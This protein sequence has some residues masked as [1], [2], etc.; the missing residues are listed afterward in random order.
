M[1][2]PTVLLAPDYGTAAETAIYRTAETI[3]PLAGVLGIAIGCSRAKGQEDA[4]SDDILPLQGGCLLVSWEHQ[5]IRDL[6]AGLKS[7]V[8]IAPVSPLLASGRPGDCFDVA[9]SL[10]RVADSAAPRDHYAF[11]A[12]PQRLLDGDT[13]IAGWS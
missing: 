1:V 9:L 6:V 4:L 11:S 2:R 12:L 8:E 10:S 3:T 7:R 13:T 5:H